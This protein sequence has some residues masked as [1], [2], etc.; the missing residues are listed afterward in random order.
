VAG[1]AAV[2]VVVGYL[3]TI[4]QQG[5]GFPPRVIFVAGWIVG[6]AVFAFS[7]AFTRAPRRRALVAGIASA[8]LAVLSVPALMSIGTALFLVALLAGSSASVAAHEGGIGPLSRIG[9]LV[10]LLF[11]TGLLLAA[12]FQFTVGS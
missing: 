12:G 8:M 9:W 7:A 10:V 5:D 6:A 1:I 2:V 11:G 4:G 3:A